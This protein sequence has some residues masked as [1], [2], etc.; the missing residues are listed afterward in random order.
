[1]QSPSWNW[2][3]TAAA[4]KADTVVLPDPE[5]PMTTAITGSVM[6]CARAGDHT[7]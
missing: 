1:M 4:S 5:T 7:R 6:V 3:P 2:Q